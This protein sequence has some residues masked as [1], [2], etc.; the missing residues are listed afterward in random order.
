MSLKSL[1]SRLRKPS[2]II[3]LVSQIVTMLL[4]FGVKV[5][6]N[7]V[8]GSVTIICSMLVTLGL[9]STPES[10]P[11]NCASGKCGVKPHVLVGDQL[12]CKECG[13]VY[14]E[15]SNL[16]AASQYG[17]DEDCL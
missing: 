2:V 7:L 3:T 17:C 15:F 9:L 10:V 4:L 13:T 16:N 5:D 8:M 11:L 12:V 6:E 14:N 1:L